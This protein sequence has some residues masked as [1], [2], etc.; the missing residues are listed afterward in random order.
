MALYRSWL[1][2][3]GN[4]QR[5]VEKAWAL[6]ADVLIYDL[7]DAVPHREKH[8]ARQIVKHAVKQNAAKRK[9]VFVRINDRTTPY[10][11]EDLADIVRPGLSGIILP[12]A[13]ADDDVRHLQR[14]LDALEEERGI[15]RE[16]IE[17]VPLIES[18]RGLVNAMAVAASGTRV[19]C[20]AFGAVDFALDVNAHL[21][22]EGKEIWYAR[23]QLVVS[24]RAA[25]IESPID[26]VFTDIVDE[27][28][29]RQDIQFARQLGFQGKLAIHPRQLEPM[30]ERFAPTEEE[31]KEAQEMVDAFA[32][33]EAAGAA[34]V[35]VNGKMVDYPVAERARRLLKQAELSG[36]KA[37]H[38]GD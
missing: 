9:T 36:E 18:A 8:A 22:R 34:A 4:R 23:S 10:Y 16:A 15:P 11:T 30:N 31:I 33:A 28:G 32:R 21:T 12:K 20:L 29:L 27:E 38:D 26:S 37:R 17:I 24:S 13:E 5:H 14:T 3:P 25:G 7:E 6:P 2:V 1:F 35:Q 19:K